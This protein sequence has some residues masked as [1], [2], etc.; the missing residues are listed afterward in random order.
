MPGVPESQQ[1]EALKTSMLMPGLYNSYGEHLKDLQLAEAFA[2]EHNLKVLKE[3]PL[4]PPASRP[5]L[6]RPAPRAVA[7]S[8]TTAGRGARA[9]PIQFRP[10]FGAAARPVREVQAL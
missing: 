9:A 3:H 8:R 5:A 7:T 2:L 4:S 10:G 6:P 1:E